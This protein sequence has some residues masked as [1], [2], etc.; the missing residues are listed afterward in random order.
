MK[1]APIGAPRVVCNTSTGAAI[2]S[3]AMKGA[4]IGAPRFG[5]FAAFGASGA[6][7]RNE[8]CSDRSTE[9]VIDEA[10][11]RPDDEVAA[12]KGAPIGAPRADE[13]YLTYSRAVGAAM[14]GAPI[15]AP[16]SRSCM[17]RGWPA[18]SRNEGC[19]DRST[20][21]ALPPTWIGWCISRRNEGCSDRSTEAS[22]SP[23]A[24]DALARPQ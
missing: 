11:S 15:G 4:P 18:R 9:E 8:G 6:A 20:E 14:K 3:A 10:F 13:S 24:A 17:R 5:A 7:G 12:M 1:G 23:R 21:A 22:R 2:R 16:R 19:S